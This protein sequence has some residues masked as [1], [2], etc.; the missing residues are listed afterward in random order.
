M[1]KLPKK[2]KSSKKKKVVKSGFGVPGRMGKKNCT[3]QSKMMDPL[4]LT[5][6]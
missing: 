5:N 4:V 2:K 6:I 1:K 3:G